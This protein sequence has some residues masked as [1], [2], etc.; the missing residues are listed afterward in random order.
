[1]LQSDSSKKSKDGDRQVEIKVAKISP[2]GWAERNG[3]AVGDVIVMANHRT[4]FHETKL[5]KPK[6]VKKEFDRVRPGVFIIR[7]EIDSRE[8]WDV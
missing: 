1:L 5:G 6:D 8:V 2:E 3:I 7:R 4:Q